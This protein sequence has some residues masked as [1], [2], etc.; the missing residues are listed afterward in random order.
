MFYSLYIKL[1]LVLFLL[2]L[3]IGA[4]FLFV[5]MYTAPMYQQEV[6]Q[7][8]NRDLAHYIVEEHVLIENGQVRQDNLAELF[9][10]VMI[11]NPSLEL[12]LLDADG[13]VIGHSMAPDKVRQK[14]V[15][16]GPINRFL[17]QPD[18]GLVMGDDPG[19]PARQNS[20][21]V[22]PIDVD[23]QRQGY[24]YAILGSEK[25]NHIS[26]VL[27]RSLIMRWSASATAAALGFAFVA[28]LLLFFFLMRKL[29][30]LSSAMQEFKN[31]HLQAAALAA[32]PDDAT[33]DEID[34]MTVTFQKMA[35]RIDEQMRHLQE[36][37]STRREMVANISH[38][39]RTPLASLSGYLETLQL[40][41]D[42][43]TEESRQAYLRI[44][45]ENALRLTRLVEELFE[46]AKLDSDDIR[47]RA[48]S[49][50]LAELA[51]DVS[52][53]FYLRAREQNIDF[54][55]VVDETVPDV[56]ADVGMIERVLDNL[57]DNSFKHTPDRGHI[58]L[59]VAPRDGNVEIAVTDT[60]YGIAADELPYVLKR[61]YRNPGNS[62]TG[63]HKPGLGLGL[64]IA[65]R[66][67]E[68]HGG[69]LQVD[70]VQHQGTTFRF[71]LPA[72]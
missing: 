36:V 20:F 11:I 67:V 32:E 38:D 7:Q 26:E 33:L 39:L 45:Y 41:S 60:G 3:G 29:R 16:L 65:S 51:F 17:E 59:Q 46:L 54:N 5:A 35:Q 24:I 62:V 23:N 28:G 55:V 40:K 14:Q 68:M 31:T 48:E 2:F 8:L 70:S 27:Q 13:R 53:K 1:V 4:V 49:F 19:Y 66:I 9:Q 44:A 12:Y 69:H 30:V 18:A 42:E 50:S 52:H 34:R 22:A 25:I 43:L 71:S 6:S 58:R 37:E 47:P 10:N 21:S 64:A 15:S 57:I 63:E 56:S 61:F 72:T